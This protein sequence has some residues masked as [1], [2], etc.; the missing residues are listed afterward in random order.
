MASQVAKEYIEQLI[1]VYQRFIERV[2]E[3]DLTNSLTLSINDGFVTQLGMKVWA[4]SPRNLPGPC[5]LFDR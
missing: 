1:S 5:R 3:G 4:E 2:T